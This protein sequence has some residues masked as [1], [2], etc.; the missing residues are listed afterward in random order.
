MRNHSI[1]LDKSR[2]CATVCWKGQFPLHFSLL[3][4]NAHWPY[5]CLEPCCVGKHPTLDCSPSDAFLK[6]AEHSGLN[7]APGPIGNRQGAGRVMKWRK[8]GWIAAC[9][10]NLSETVKLKQPRFA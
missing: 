1:N 5:A 6:L 10:I 4:T 7:S 9:P 8:P 2:V 3:L